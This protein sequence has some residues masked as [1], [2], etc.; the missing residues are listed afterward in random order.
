MASHVLAESLPGISSGQ[1][2]FVAII[3][4]VAILALVFAFVL[5]KEV[6]KADQGTDNMKR[7]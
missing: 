2:G 7:I 4:I 3:A 5:V 6:L 1:K